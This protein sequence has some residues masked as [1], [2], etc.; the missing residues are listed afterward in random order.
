MNDLVAREWSISPSGLRL[1]WLPCAMAMMYLATI[2][3]PIENW[4]LIQKSFC[5]TFDMVKVAELTAEVPQLPEIVEK[6][7]QDSDAKTKCQ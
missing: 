4:R 3:V 5:G 7:K 2:P 1:V 6:Q